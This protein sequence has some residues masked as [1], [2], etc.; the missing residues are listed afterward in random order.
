VIG[1][2]SYGAYIPYHRLERK[3]IAQAF[4]DRPQSGEK[5]VANFDEDSVSIAVGAALDCL[6]G[7]DEKAV[8]VLYFA[9]TT[10]PYEEK[11]SASTM[12]AALDLRQ[13]VR[14]MDIAGSLRAA[15][16]ALLAAIDH[17]SGGTGKALV[18]A[19]DCRLGAPQ[20]QNELAFGDGGA[21]LLLGSGDDVIARVVA[22]H[23]HTREQIGIWREDDDPFVRSWEDRYVYQR[24]GETVV[25]CIKGILAKSGL[26]PADVAKVALAGPA[27]R[28]QL[29]IAGKL[30]FRQEQIQDPLHEWIG[31][32]GT[33]HPLVMLAAALE[34][35]EP[36]DRLLL[37]G[38]G[39]GSDAILLEV[40]DA[41]K[42]LPPRI[43]VQGH[44]EP[45]NNQLL[46]TH[47]LKW[48]GIL[49]TEPARRPETPRPSVPAMYRNYGQNLG[50]YGSQCQECGT[51]QFPKQ[52]V[53]AQC[54][55]RD[56]MTDYR[57][58]GKTATVATFTV[59]YLAAS[60]A[61]PTV[62]AVIDFA[63]GGR[64]MCEVT[65]CDPSELKIGMEVEMTFR[66]LF[67]AGGIH[68]YFWKAK[69][70]RQVAKP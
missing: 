23:S 6:A 22:V 10:A 18:T 52:R 64:M 61:P 20:G 3:K 50:L 1:I 68:N 25:P 62:V 11:Q 43:G 28:V 36:G 67:Q 30:G 31:S 4:G 54:Q 12:A 29:Q 57:F 53:C 2:V 15:T 21:A 69:P 5:A 33:A 46:Y 59:D 44:L 58:Y 40:T 47:Y 48:R 70:K 63:G 35:A 38:F 34:Q 32:T 55:A 39:E 49:P 65:D 51:P 66:R 9:S 13:N 16:S 42:R 26:Q 7:M 60:P 45:K 17:V 24:Y 37:V 56:R 19:A 27:P 14:V 8:D 41:I